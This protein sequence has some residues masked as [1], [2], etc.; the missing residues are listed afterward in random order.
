VQ[1]IKQKRIQDWKSR[2]VGL[3]E[4]NRREMKTP[5]MIEDMPNGFLTVIYQMRKR[6]NRRFNIQVNNTKEYKLSLKQR[7]LTFKR[8]F[9]LMQKQ[10]M[11][12]QVNLISKDLWLCSLVIY[13][14]NTYTLIQQEEATNQVLLQVQCQI[15]AARVIWSRENLTELCTWEDI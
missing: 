14:I 7:I 1:H 5:K 8:W 12:L 15:K 10:S 6:K 4:G 11:L 9:K 3:A 2:V 13:Q